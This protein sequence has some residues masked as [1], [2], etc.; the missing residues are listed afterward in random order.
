M[1]DYVNI[2]RWYGNRFRVVLNLRAQ[3][4]RISYTTEGRRETL[5]KY[6]LVWMDNDRLQKYKSAI[7]LT[8]LSLLN[9]TRTHL[10][11]KSKQ[12]YSTP[13]KIQLIITEYIK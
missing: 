1:R 3:F 9:N 6:I 12:H 10:Y 2:V 8:I 7:V 5:G 11:F 13:S 4:T